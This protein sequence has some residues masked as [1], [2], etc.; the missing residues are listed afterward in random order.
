LR[1]CLVS[2]LEVRLKQALTASFFA[3][4]GAAS[5]SNDAAM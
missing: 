3:A 4:A 2:L 1:H 5:T